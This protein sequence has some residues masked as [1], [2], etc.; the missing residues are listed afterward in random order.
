MRFLAVSLLILGLSGCGTLNSSEHFVTRSGSEMK[1]RCGCAGNMQ[2]TTNMGPNCGPCCSE[3]D[4][5]CNQVTQ[6]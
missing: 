3:D 4:C 5:K 6:K 1:K 2:C